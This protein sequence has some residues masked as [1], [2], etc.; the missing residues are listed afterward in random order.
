MRIVELTESTKKNLLKDLLKRSPSS[1]PEFEQR[2]ND[3]IEN[4]KQ[5]KDRAVFGYTKQFDGFDVTSEN[6]PS[7][8]RRSKRL[9]RWLMQNCWMSLKNL[10]LISEATMRNRKNTAGL[11][12]QKTERCWDRRLRL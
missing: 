9:T 1:Y 12:A 2:V 11:T 10:W 3:I 5:N 4:V 7:Q 6:V 8:K